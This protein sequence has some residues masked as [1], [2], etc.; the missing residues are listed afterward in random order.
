MKNY[1]ALMVLSLALFTTGCT[2]VATMGMSNSDVKVMKR[3]D[4]TCSFMAEM[5]FAIDCDFKT[6]VYNGDEPVEIEGENCKIVRDK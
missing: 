2:Q 1:I 6:C 4:G 5:L 3:L